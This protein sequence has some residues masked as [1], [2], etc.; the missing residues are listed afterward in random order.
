MRLRSLDAV[1]GVAA[2]AVVLYHASL[3]LPFGTSDKTTEL[4]RGV[5]DSPV[6][7]NATPLRLLVAGPGAVI[8]F[9]ALSGFVLALSLQGSSPLKGYPAFLIKRVARIWLPF[10]AAI[11]LSATLAALIGSAPLPTVSAWFNTSWSE[12]IT[13]KLL[14]KTLL[15]TGQTT[16]LNLPM[17]SL[18]VEMVISIAFPLLV[19]VTRSNWKGAL[20]AAILLGAGG[21]KLLGMRPQAWALLLAI[22]YLFPFTL[23]IVIAL[24]LEA[25]RGRM[26]ALGRQ[27]A[28]ILMLV[29]LS[30]LSLLP[31]V[32]GYANR[33]STEML[34]IADSFAAITAMIL[35]TVRGE[36]LSFLSGKGPRFLGKISYSLYL[37]H[38]P[39]L[40]ATVRVLSTT[41]VSV[42]V[43][44]GVALSV[45]VAT[46]FQRYVEVP[47]S[48]LGQRLASTL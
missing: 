8:L 7:L 14:L 5:T 46:L 45:G 39:V 9:F 34:I 6:W 44:I 29:C 41:P 48:G 26:A 35:A 27:R 20:L 32:P 36:A 15:M 31:V 43:S 10:V 2:A 4:A 1:R 21:A 47:A 30:V 42:S 37:V 23:G 3:I 13:P 17:W 25:A 19:V 16:S 12:P 18:I 38:L 22:P 11:V 28:N 33:L 24:H 40:V